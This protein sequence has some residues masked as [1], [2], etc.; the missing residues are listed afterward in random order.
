[1]SI[2]RFLTTPCTIYATSTSSTDA[3]GVPSLTVTSVE[4]VCHVQPY[5]PVG[6][7]EVLVGR[8][9]AGQARR[10]WFPT[11]TALAFTSVVVVGGDAFRV[12]GDPKTWTVGYRSD[13]VEAI[14]VRQA[15]SSTVV[16]S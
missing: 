8:D 6:A 9:E 4:T 10:V 1:M 12:A 13:H 16:S 11:G 2:A 5:E 3:D 14:L 15:S 7:D